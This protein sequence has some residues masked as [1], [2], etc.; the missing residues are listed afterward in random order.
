MDAMTTTVRA[1]RSCMA[2]LG[3]LKPLALASMLAL[4]A[5]ADDDG[6]AKEV[7]KAQDRAAED[8]AE[9]REEAA[10]DIADAERE[11]AD[12]RREFRESTADAGDD[13]RA[14]EA[15]AAGIRFRICG[16]AKPRQPGSSSNGLPKHATNS[17]SGSVTATPI[18]PKRS[19]P[20]NTSPNTALKQ[21]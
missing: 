19:A 10:K 21:S 11:V 5:C 18:P 3:S 17:Q 4:A 15:N 16:K 8:L 13:L 20:A 9:A 2:V 14:A 12:A 7:A 6:S 1:T